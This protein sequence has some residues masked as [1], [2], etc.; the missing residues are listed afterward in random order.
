VLVAA[1]KRDM[2]LDKGDLNDIMLILGEIRGGLNTASAESAKRSDRQSLAL[3]G[4]IL[5]MVGVKVLGTDPLLDIATTLA[6][7]GT[8]LLFGSL[9]AGVQFI[10]TGKRRVTMTGRWLTVVVGCLI[11]TQIA[12][13]FRDLGILDARIVYLIRSVQN[14][15]I[16]MFGWKLI[17]HSEIFESKPPQGE[18]HE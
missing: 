16:L 5:A 4:V 14:L 10:R 17:H 7:I 2:S 9:V 6:I 13:Y 18:K 12:V 3:I 11:I 8:V 1:G 15:C